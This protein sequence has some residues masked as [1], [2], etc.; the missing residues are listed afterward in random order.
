MNSIFNSTKNIISNLKSIEKSDYELELRFGNLFK[1]KFNPDIGKNIFTKIFEL[2]TINREYE[3]LENA[4]INDKYYT[5]GTVRKIKKVDELMFD[6]KN[7]RFYKNDDKI[8]TIYMKKEKLNQITKEYLRISFNKEIKL[9]QILDN[10][11]KYERMKYRV[12]IPFE[13]I[14]RFDF[15]IENDKNYS[16]E[17][18]ILLEKVVLKE[19][20]EQINKLIKFLD[21]IINIFK[22]NIFNT[23]FPP[24]PHT[25][26]YSDLFIINSNS[27]AVTDKADGIRAF[28]KIHNKKVLLINPKTKHIMG[29][30]GK[31]NLGNTL[32]DGE[33]VN[34]KFYAFDIMFFDNKDVRMLNLLE[35]L[36]ILKENINKIKIHLYLKVKTFYTE[37]IFQKS[38]E[39]LNTRFS[40]NIDGLIYTPIYQNYSNNELPI[41]KWKKRH[42]IDV[43]VSYNRKDNYTYFIYGKRYGRINEWCTQYFEKRQYI[44]TT[45]SRLK[46][47]NRTFHYQEYQDLKNKRIHFGKY[48]HFNSTF[49]QEK[50]LGK[51]GRPNENSITG[52]TLNRNIDVIL[53]KYDIIEYEFRHG[54]WYPL[55][56]RTFD[57]DEAN[58]IKTIESVLKVIEENLTIEKII[59]FTKTYKFRGEK[60]GTVYNIVAQD[61]AF[62]RDNWRKFHNYVKRKSILNASNN[63][64]GKSYLDL[65]CG[66][67]GDL[68]KYIN[69]GYKNILAIDTSENELYCKNG[70]IH[71]LSNMG[72][73]N[74]GMYY[75]K[76]GIQ[77]TVLCGDISKNI[78]SGEF[79]KNEND[80]EKLNY[81]FQKVDKFDTISIMFAIHYMLENE[82]KM[83]S[84]MDN[85]DE[86]LKHDGKFIGVYLN[87]NDN[88][89]YTFKDNG[90]TFYEINNKDDKIEIKNSVWGIENKLEEPK[91]NKDK[92]Q[93]WFDLYSFIDVK[94]N[95]FEEFYEVFKMNEGILLTEDEKRLGYMNNHFILIRSPK[96]IQKSIG[97]SL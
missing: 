7:Y 86:L 24:Q 74:K 61:K 72:F 60:V 40:Y 5:S 68:Q 27:Y 9:K 58:A 65:A 20:Q 16:V 69:L 12:S 35:R 19:Y 37:N 83:D 96:M 53:D 4:F 77:V 10:N 95:S 54:E 32:I 64:I 3:L 50:F 55:R 47:M 45:D 79:L 2:L 52:R 48:K 8:E 31:V 46:K 63:C 6:T 87:I 89:D 59:D 75:E 56:K 17:I 97:I 23:L 29:D 91:I 14:F 44:R 26:N 11:L 81:F 21:P 25:M 93:D 62:K 85:I 82:D 92:L 1:G 70:Y 30:Y 73:I 43:R 36:T 42:T 28:L 51:P 15:T 34:N 38:Q 22:E 49:F 66:K 71:R 88:K 67:G 84:F 41:F 76:N 13:K 90:I 39:I 78:K 33:F 80:I 18:E 57:K 94:H